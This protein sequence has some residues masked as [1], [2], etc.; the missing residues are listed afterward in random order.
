VAGVLTLAV[1]PPR[2][3]RDVDVLDRHI[4]EEGRLH[5]TRLLTMKGSLPA[6]IQA[7]VPVRRMHMLET[8]IVDP[9]TEQMWVSTCNLNCTSVIQ[10]VS[11]STY[12]PAHEEDAQTRYR[13]SIF[14]RA[15]PKR[16]QEGP[17]S[18]SLLSASQLAEQVRLPST[19]ATSPPLSLGAAPRPL[20][21]SI[22][23]R[24]AQRAAC[25]G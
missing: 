19:G 20:P 21:S 3:V 18:S 15:F 13:I 23:A 7:F 6:F 5:S 16:R 2:Y 17:G 22:L 1:G 12:T 24:A 8:V 25:G 11:E 14:V 4:D 10:A 9:K